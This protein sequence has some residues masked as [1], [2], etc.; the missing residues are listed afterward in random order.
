VSVNERDGAA[1]A[2]FCGLP[3]GARVVL[4]QMSQ[5]SPRALSG[6]EHS[7]RLE[8]RSLLLT[9]SGPTGN[10][11]VLTEGSVITPT[12]GPGAM[13]RLLKGLEAGSL[14]WSSDYHN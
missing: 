8:A 6:L 7:A 13:D 10:V 3:C 12:A 5:R 2:F 14:R 4:G 11:G 1:S 9:T